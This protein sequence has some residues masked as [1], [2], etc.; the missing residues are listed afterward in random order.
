MVVG[1]YYSTA[2]S[3]FIAKLLDLYGKPGHFDMLMLSSE[4]A[5]EFEHSVEGSAPIV[6]QN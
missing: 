1:I 5:V 3:S 6:L 2:T 4:T